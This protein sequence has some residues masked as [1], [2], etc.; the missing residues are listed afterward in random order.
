MSLV[1]VLQCVF[2]AYLSGTLFTRCHLHRCAIVFM[3]TG[4]GG[5]F[6]I[7]Y[8][9]YT[10]AVPMMPMH[11][12]IIGIP[13]VLAF[14]WLIP[15][16]PKNSHDKSMVDC[17]LQIVILFFIAIAMLFPKDFYLPFIR[18]ISIWSHMFL[19]F[20]IVAKGALIYAGIVAFSLLTTKTT[21]NSK[22]TSPIMR[23]ILWGYGFLTLAMFSGET[24]SYLGWGTPVVWHDPAITTILAI[25]FYWT[26]LL[27]LHYIGYWSVRRRAAFTV[28]GGLL[29]VVLTIHPDM[30]PFRLPRFPG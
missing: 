3:L 27:H 24:W 22:H 30:G 28:L 17:L 10:E 11:L 20:E 6:F 13:A 16:L 15:L 1:L 25:W 18:S 8:S 23:F 26:C 12:G 29:V 2:I 4:C 9:R 7:F 5:N 14:L 19:L 21:Q